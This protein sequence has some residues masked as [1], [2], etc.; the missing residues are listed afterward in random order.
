MN[1]SFLIV[2][3]VIEKEKYSSDGIRAYMENKSLMDRLNTPAD[4][5]DKKQPA[6]TETE[7]LKAENERLKAELKQKNKTPAQAKPARDFILNLIKKEYPNGEFKGWKRE[8]VAT[9]AQE[10]AKAAGFGENDIPTKE[11]IT[12]H[13]FNAK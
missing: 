2:E 9:E 11:T 7:A 10:R 8:S 3:H 6:E 4:T 1:G 5:S 12:R 13:Y